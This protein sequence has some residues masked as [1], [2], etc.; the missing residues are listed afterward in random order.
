MLY[1]SLPTRSS[2]G[3]LFLS[4]NKAQALDRINVRAVLVGSRLED[5]IRCLG[6]VAWHMRTLPLPPLG[7]TYEQ[8]TVIG[9]APSLARDGYR[10]R[11]VVKCKCG[12]I[13]EFVLSVLKRGRTNRCR[14]CSTKRTIGTDSERYKSVLGQQFGDRV[15]IALAPS[16]RREGSR[17]ASSRVIC[18]CKCGLIS[19]CS[20]QALRKG[21]STRCHSCAR[22]IHG[23]TAKP[24]PNG[25]RGPTPE[26]RS[27]LG[28]NT[29]C[30]NPNL[31]CYS[32]YGGRGITVAPEWH[33]SGGF[34][35]FL[36]YIGPRPTP[37]HSIDRIDVNGNY[38]PGNVKWATRKEQTA[39]RR[40]FKQID[41]A[42]MNAEALTIGKRH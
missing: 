36:A 8:W 5:L 41:L 9:T 2:R 32:Y 3:L 19:E 25:K 34:Q 1:S 24:T 40:T 28:M 14:S 39:N 4:L 12:Q 27:W 31:P 30:F 7:T 10:T 35:R 18:Q 37:L 15:V 6:F 42:A 33:G 11:V 13:Q 20:L 21:K 38:E 16:R 29:R 17:A 26:Y 22:I 23:A